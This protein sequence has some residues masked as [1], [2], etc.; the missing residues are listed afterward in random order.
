MGDFC[1]PTT[2]EQ[3]FVLVYFIKRDAILGK[4]E[5]DS[6]VLNYEHKSLA[7]VVELFFP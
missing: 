3:D 7:E 6:R 5:A 2:G 4:T 1:R